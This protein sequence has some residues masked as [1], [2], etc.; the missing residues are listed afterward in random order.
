VQLV[1]AGPLRACRGKL[2]LGP[3]R[4]QEVHAASFLRQRRMVLDEALRGSVEELSR[5]ALHELFHFVWIRLNNQTRRSWE[6]LVGRQ[7]R[8]GACGELG[9]SAEQRLKALRTEDMAE[10]TRRWRDYVCE[11][12]CDGAACCFGIARRHEEFTL[13][14]RFRRERQRWF[15]GLWR[16]RHGVF[17]I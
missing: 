16:H 2:R 1:W 10:R 5:I 12:F 14:S 11:S 8:E 17:P 6:E 9:W 4:G 13:T 3:G 15:A 7:I